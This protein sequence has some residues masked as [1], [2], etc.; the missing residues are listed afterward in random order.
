MN[1]RTIDVGK[2]GKRTKILGVC[3][4]EGEDGTK[5]PWL[6][7]ASH[8]READGSVRVAMCLRAII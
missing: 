7:Y 3:V 1:M 5:D 8:G 2:L 4:K 6:E